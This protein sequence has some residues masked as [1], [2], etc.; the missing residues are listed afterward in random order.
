MPAR[1]LQRYRL[2]TGTLP[3]QFDMGK[4][5]LSGVVSAELRAIEMAIAAVDAPA[6][7]RR[8][9]RWQEAPQRGSCGEVARD[10]RCRFSHP[11]FSAW[12]VSWAHLEL[13]T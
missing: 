12:Q 8:L 13:Q 7:K 6:I 10:F 3:Q 9:A 1:L 2:P 5:D 4:I 11:V